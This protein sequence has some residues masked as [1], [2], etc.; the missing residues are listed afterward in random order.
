MEEAEVW[1]CCGRR[2]Q[3]SDLGVA[4]IPILSWKSM[5][6][7]HQLHEEQWVF[8]GTP[9]QGKNIPGVMGGGGEQRTKIRLDRMVAT[10]EW[11]DLFPEVRVRH[12]AM[13]VSDHCMLM[14]TLKHKQPQRRGM[15]CFFFEAMWTREERCREIV[16]EAWELGW[17]EAECGIIDG[18]KRCQEQLQDWNWKEFGNINKVLKQKKERLQQLEFWDSLH[19]KAEEIQKVRKE[20]NEIQAREEVLWNQRSKALWLKWGDRNTKLLHATTSQRH[21]KNWIVGLQNTNEVWVE[22]KEGIESNI[23]D[24]FEDIY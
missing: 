1:L 11:M 5:G 22:D 9:M 2:A 3:T 18:I 6:A 21:R 15:K 19:G 4:Q 13:S 17:V 14:L 23:M 12:V 8:T 7:R 10:E 20:I 16:E 24:Y